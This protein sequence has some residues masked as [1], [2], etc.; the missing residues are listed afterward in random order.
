MASQ[1]VRLVTVSVDDSV[2]ERA[3]MQFL[4]SIQVRT[5]RYIKRTA[6]DAAFIDAVDTAWSGALPALF[7]YDRSG[8]QRAR[9]VGE[10]E[11]RAVEQAVTSLLER[12]TP[13]PSPASPLKPAPH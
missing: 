6:R 8:R 10:T 3:A 11:R 2:D 7:I 5:P 12:A 9:F 13:T 4:D 1:G